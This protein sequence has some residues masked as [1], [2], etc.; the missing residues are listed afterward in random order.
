MYGF[1]PG[2]SKERASGSLDTWWTITQSSVSPTTPTWGQDNRDHN[3]F[4]RYHTQQTSTCEAVHEIWIQSWNP[5]YV[6]IIKEGEQGSRVF[7]NIIFRE[8]TSQPIS[9]RQKYRFPLVQS[10]WFLAQSVL[11]LS[12]VSLSR[13]F[14]I[15]IRP[16]RSDS[17]SLSNPRWR[18]LVFLEAGNCNKL[19]HCSK[20]KSYFSFLGAVLSFMTEFD[21]LKIHSKYLMRTIRL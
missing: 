5:A 8:K 9:I 15:A 19:I 7:I 3:D 16:W 4:S 14:F 17:G 6:T 10:W 18:Y 2:T 1:S 13:D 11:F 12:P 20:C 21:S